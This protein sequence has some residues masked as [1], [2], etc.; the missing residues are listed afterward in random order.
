MPSLA[1]NVLKLKSAANG[2]RAVY[3]IHGHPGLYLHVRGNGT[4]SWIVRYRIGG[5]M[6]ERVLSNDAARANFEAITTAKDEI[7]LAVKTRG[8]D[9]W[10]ERQAEAEAKAAAERAKKL[11]LGT[12]IDQ[13]I[14]K[15]RTKALRPRTVKLYRSTFDAYVVPTFGMRPVADITKTE[16][17]DHFAALKFRL[18]KKGGR[19]TRAEV[20]GKAHS[21]LEAVFEFAVDEGYIGASP[22]RGL[23]RPVPKEPEQKSSRPL[24]PA[25]LRAVWQGADA[26]LSPAFARMIKL[27]LLLGRRRAEVS[28]A[29]KDEFHLDGKTPHWIVPPREGNKSALAALVPLPR[30]SLAIINA[31]WTDAASSNYLFPQS[32]GPHDLPTSPDP[33]TRAWRDLC[34]AIGVPDDVN[35]H[36]ARG[37]LTDA[38]EVMGVPDNI[39]S[40]CLHHTSDMKGTTAKRVYSTNQFHHEKRRALRLWELRLR[41]I[42]SGK[43]PHTLRWTP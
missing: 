4:A 33:V 39:V 12:V 29:R 32:R 24:R 5:A 7:R 2:T 23:Q 25:E 18:L 14:A 10:A 43:R 31:A 36:D 38:L 17:R 1:P 19:V 3:T 42:V 15:P 30:V 41:S 40:H 6:K 9:L 21:Y 37:L 35:L 28:G 11:T 27:L 16:L 13:W 26:H 22:M 34:N 8:I 20:V